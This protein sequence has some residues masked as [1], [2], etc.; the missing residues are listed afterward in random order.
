M[1][2]ADAGD[3]RTRYHTLR[4]L[5][6]TFPSVAAAL[7]A[8]SGKP[9]TIDNAK[10]AAHAA[11]FMAL[12]SG[13]PATSD[14]SAY[15]SDAHPRQPPA[16]STLYPATDIVAA[17]IKPLVPCNAPVH[18]GLPTDLRRVFQAA[19]AE[20]PSQVAKAITRLLSDVA[21]VSTGSNIVMAMGRSTYLHRT[22]TERCVSCCRDVGV[23][24]RPMY[25]MRDAPHLWQSEVDKDMQGF[26]FTPR[27]FSSICLSMQVDICW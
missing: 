5:H 7:E 11:H 10:A 23:L 8:A 2:T 25:G 20:L 27:V 16:T 19:F 15:T 22:T 4:L 9:L 13:A 14:L 1:H 6:N 12:R 17:A 26:H 24:R 18:D 21:S 3:P